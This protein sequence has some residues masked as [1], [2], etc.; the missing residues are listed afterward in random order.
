MRRLR[1][2]DNSDQREISVLPT[3]LAGYNIPDD[4]FQ[5]SRKRRDPGHRT[6]GANCGDLCG[7]CESRAGLRGR[8]AAWRPADNHERRGKLPGLSGW[9]AGTRDDAGFSKAGRAIWHALRPGQC[10][11]R[12]PRFA[13][14]YRRICGRPTDYSPD[15]HHCDGGL[16]QMA[17]DP[18]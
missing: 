2:R 16:G 18:K 5:R 3:A 15:G 9:C 12:Q 6:R 13:A 7:A 4:Q 10:Q 1:V 11:I 8:R 17:R 14:V